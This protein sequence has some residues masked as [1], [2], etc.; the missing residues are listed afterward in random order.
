MPSVSG[1]LVDVNV[2]VFIAFSKRS[3]AQPGR[4]KSA[5]AARGKQ[6]LGSIRS[7][8]VPPLR[9]C[10]R[11]HP[12]LGQCGAVQEAVSVIARLEDVAVMRA[13]LLREEGRRDA[14]KAAVRPQ[15]L[16]VLPLGSN[17]LRADAA[18][19]L[20]LVQALASQLAVE[21]LD[22]ALLHWPSPGSIR[23]CR[24][25]CACARAM[26]ARVVN[27]GRL[28]CEPVLDVARHLRSCCECD[29]APAVKAFCQLIRDTMLQLHGA[30]FRRGREGIIRLIGASK[31]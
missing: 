16:V 28:S 4:A 21:G 22:V 7:A 30:D 10:L 3:G 26:N 29:I 6:S 19:E 15:L 12:L 11:R 23:V 17:P 18:S 20:L 2:L 9:G 31:Q 14:S 8:S 1:P 24:M 13:M 5:V 27:S 25:P